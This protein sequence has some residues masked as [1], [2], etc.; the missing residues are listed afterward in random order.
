MSSSS[1]AVTILVLVPLTPDTLLESW[2][3][4]LPANYT[5]IYRPQN[6][7]TLP[8]ADEYANTDAIFMF[9]FPSNLSVREEARE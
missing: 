6:E 4:S 9:Q 5:V 3:S 8:T 2:K 7:D 1:A